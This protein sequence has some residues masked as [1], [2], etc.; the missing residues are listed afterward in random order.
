MSIPQIRL[1]GEGDAGPNGAPPGD[2]YIELS[3]KPHQFFRR[4]GSDS[5]LDLPV[6]IAKAALGADLQVPTIG[7]GTAELKVAARHAARQ[8]VP[9]ARAGRAASARRGPGRPDG[10]REA[11]RCRPR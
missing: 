10:A 5:R 6:N 8:G 9:A 1:A 2:L 3:M 7:G 4:Q 11:S